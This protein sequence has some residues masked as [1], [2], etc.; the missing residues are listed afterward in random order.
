VAEVSVLRL[1]Q[2][3]QAGWA[4]DIVH[5]GDTII[6]LSALNFIEKITTD[7]N[8]F[9]SEGREAR[10]PTTEG[11]TA[12]WRQETTAAALA[13]DGQVAAGKANA[14]EV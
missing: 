5:L 12:L 10:A 3:I 13:E 1:E 14:A 11:T 6:E 9:I 4:T 8:G 7:E 2:A